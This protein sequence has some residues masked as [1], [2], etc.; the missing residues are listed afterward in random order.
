MPRKSKKEIEAEFL[1]KARRRFRN[2]VSYEYDDRSE[3][4]DDLR[5]KLGGR[6]QWPDDIAS[7]RED[8]GRP[9]LTINKL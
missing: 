9:V 5:F 4:L 2:S 7:E 1:D 3:G 8:A 6:N